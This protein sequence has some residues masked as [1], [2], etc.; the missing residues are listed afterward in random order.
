M[1]DSHQNATGG[2]VATYGCIA[3]FQWGVVRSAKLEDL[4][5]DCCYCQT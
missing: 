4:A 2:A 5:D 1:I 3:L